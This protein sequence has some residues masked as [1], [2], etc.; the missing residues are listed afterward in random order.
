[1]LTATGW[2]IK[3]NVYD[4]SDILLAASF[5]SV[6]MHW[7][8]D[9]MQ[10]D[11]FNEIMHICARSKKKQDSCQGDSGGM[12]NCRFE[13]N[14]SIVV[15]NGTETKTKS[16]NTTSQLIIFLSFFVHYTVYYYMGAVHPQIV[17]FYTIFSIQNNI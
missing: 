11:D 13:E 3:N 5:T 15:K 1:M 2:G 6:E 17:F 14:S 8:Q 7:C 9:S 10:I 16:F 12:F 4:T